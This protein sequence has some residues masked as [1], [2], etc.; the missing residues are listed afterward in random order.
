L[1]SCQATDEEIAE[2]KKGD[3]RDELFGA[4]DREA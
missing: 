2:A 4:F 3:L 1:D